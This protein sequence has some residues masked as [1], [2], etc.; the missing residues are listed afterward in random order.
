MAEVHSHADQDEEDRHE[1]VGHWLDPFLN[2]GVVFCLGQHKPGRQGSD[3]WRETD[4]VGRIAQQQSEDHRRNDEGASGVHFVDETTEQVCV[5]DAEQDSQGK[6]QDCQAG[7]PA[8]LKPGDDARFG[9]SDDHRQPHQGQN[10][11]QNGGS[12][13]NVAFSGR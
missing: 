12:K 5:P 8:H 7:S 9:H 4:C 2:M 10:V 11:V 1:H 6:K 3:E 13:N